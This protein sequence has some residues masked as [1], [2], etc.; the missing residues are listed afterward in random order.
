MFCSGPLTCTFLQKLQAAG[1]EVPEGGKKGAGPQEENKVLKGE[2]KTLTEELE[3]TKKGEDN[4]RTEGWEG[5][6]L[7]PCR[8][9][10]CSFQSYIT[11]TCSPY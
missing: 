1:I 4:Q 9:R 11:L 10:I 3:T 8:D 7:K 2:L 6:G 5:L